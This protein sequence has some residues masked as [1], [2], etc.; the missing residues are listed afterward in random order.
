MNVPPPFVVFSDLDGT[1]LDHDTYDWAA[2]RPSL[3]ALKRH[4]IPL[5]LASS[6]TAQEIVLIQKELGLSSLPAIVENGAGCLGTGWEAEA[7]EA[8]YK[9]IRTT[10]AQMPSDLRR[11]FVGFGDMGLDQVVAVTGLSVESAARAQQR[12][13]SE[14]GLW[15]GTDTER[16]LFEHVLQQNGI[17]V[18]QGG[19][20]LTLS[21][22]HTKAKRMQE[23]ATQYGNAPTVALG[24]APND[25]EMLENADVGVIIRNPHR[26]PLG[27]LQGEA[28]GRIFRT[29]DPGPLGWNAAML[30]IIARFEEE[31]RLS[32]D[33]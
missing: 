25:I 2:A 33:G 27:R 32:S 8:E 15:Q 29:D 11:H 24:D 30:S 10:L 26:A 5:V 12:C 18:R 19:R 16:A 6:K 13:F 20:F 28:T 3:A 14:P 23:I 22:G 4:A 31:T 9:K 21:F 7:A 17:S 1:L